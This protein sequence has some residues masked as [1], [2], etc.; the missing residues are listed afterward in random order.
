MGA[1]AFGN[2]LRKAG[3]DELTVVHSAI[4]AIPSDADVIVVHE[5]LAHRA[6]AARPGVEMVTIQNFLGDPALETLSDRLT[7][8]GYSV[9]STTDGESGLER[10]RPRSGTT[11]PAEP[12][13]RPSPSQNGN[14]IHVSR[15]T[16]VR[17]IS[18]R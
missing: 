15:D 6:R 12:N 11:M 18:A 13:S 14:Q 3:R 5:N 1:S 17:T 9:E 8:E 10:A 4:E 2:E 7:R 16:M